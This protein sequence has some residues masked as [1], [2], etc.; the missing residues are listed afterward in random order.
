[1][2]SNNF[3]MQKVKVYLGIDDTELY[4]EKLDI[5]IGGGVSKLASEGV[6]NDE[7]FTEMVSE[8]DTTIPNLSKDYIVCLSYQVALDLNLDMDLQTFYVQYVSRVNELRCYLK[9]IAN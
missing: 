7:R 3:L 6:P 4:D 5:L 2:L 1:M 9:T 8:E